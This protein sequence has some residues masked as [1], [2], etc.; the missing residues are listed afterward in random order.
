MKKRMNRSLSLLL[1]LV[2]CI[3]LLPPLPARAE[4]SV[5]LNLDGASSG[6]ASQV[7]QIPLAVGYADGDDHLSIVAEGASSTLY[8]NG[9]GDSVRRL[10]LYSA[11]QLSELSLAGNA[12]FAPG[13][14]FVEGCYGE[15]SGMYHALYY[16]VAEVTVSGSFQVK[17]G[18]D[19]V[20]DVTMSAVGGTPD[21]PL[22]TTIYVK[23]QTFTDGVLSSFVVRVSGFKLPTDQANSYGLDIG[24]NK[25]LYCQSLTVDGAGIDLTFN[26]PS[27]YIINGWPYLY[28]DDEAAFYFSGSCLSDGSFRALST[29]DGSVIDRCT[30]H[31]S[32]S[33]AAYPSY[34]GNNANFPS[35]NACLF[36]V[37]PEPE[38]PEFDGPYYVLEENAQ[39]DPG[40]GSFVVTRSD[41][42]VYVDPSKETPDLSDR[43]VSVYSAVGAPGSIQLDEIE[44]DYWSPAKSSF[45]ARFPR[46][47]F[48]GPGDY[49]IAFRFQKAEQDDIYRAI[50][51]HYIDPDA[52]LPSVTLAKTI[53]DDPWFDATISDLGDYDGG[54][55][56]IYANGT[57]LYDYW[58]GGQLTS[59]TPN[60]PIYIHVRLMDKQQKNLGRGTYSLSFVFSKDGVD[61]AY[62]SVELNYPFTTTHPPK[63]ASAYVTV[64]SGT[65]RAETHGDVCLLSGEDNAKFMVHAVPSEE[66]ADA[67]EKLYLANSAIQG[68][69]LPV[70][71]RFYAANNQLLANIGEEN[72]TNGSLI[73]RSDGREFAGLVDYGNIK[74]AVRAEVW[75][76]PYLEY[77]PGVDPIGISL[78][79]STPEE[80]KTVTYAPTVETTRQVD[81]SGK[82]YDAVKPGSTIDCIFKTDNPVGGTGQSATLTYI[83]MDNQEHTTTVAATNTGT[84]VSTAG[85]SA[86]TELIASIPVPG[87]AV[88][89]VSVTYTAPGSGGEGGVSTTYQIGKGG[90][91]GG[92]SLPV[93]KPV[94][95]TG[96]PAAYAGTV[97]SVQKV[98]GNSVSDVMSAVVTAANCA[99]IE[100]GEL[101]AGSYIWEI[102]GESGHIAGGT[103]IAPCADDTLALSDLPELTTLTVGAATAES[104]AYTGIQAEVGLTLTAPDNKTVN[105][106]GALS[107]Q[108]G[109]A[110]HPVAAA[111]AAFRQL[112]V[113]STITAATLSYDAAAYPDVSGYT[114]SLAELTE[115]QKTLATGEN[116]LSLFTFNAYTKHK[117]TG[118]VAHPEGTSFGPHVVVVLTQNVPRNG[119]A[120]NEVYTA[121]TTVDWQN[122]FS[123]EVYDGVAGT[124]E[125]RSLVFGNQAKSFDAGSVDRDIGECR[126]ASI[127]T[128]IRVDLNIQTP[129]PI[130]RRGYKSY[131]ASAST[132]VPG[133]SGTLLVKQVRTYTSSGNKKE[134]HYYEPGQLIDGSKAFE[135]MLIDGQLYVK[136][137]AAAGTP[138]AVEFM[139]PIYYGDD[140]MTLINPTAYVGGYE[141]PR[142]VTTAKLAGGEL[143]AKVASEDGDKT[144]FLCLVN[145]SRYTQIINGVNITPQT[146]T[147]VSGKGE[148]HL[149]YTAAQV[150]DYWNAERSNV[151][152]EG[153]LVFSL[154]CLDSDADA[155]KAMLESDLN[156]VLEKLD[157]GPGRQRERPFYRT[158]LP[159]NSYIYLNE[160]PENMV[161]WSTVGSEILPAYTFTYTASLGT[162][163]NNKDSVLISGTLK[164]RLANMPDADVLR[165]VQVTTPGQRSSGFDSGGNPTVE[166]INT[167]ISFTINGSQIGSGTSYIWYGPQKSRVTEYNV[168][169]VIP[170]DYYNRVNFSIVLTMGA[171]NRS[172]TTTQVIAISDGVDI[173]SLSGPTEVS[174]HDQCAAQNKIYDNKYLDSWELKLGLRATE[175]KNPD[176][177]KVTIWDN[178]VAIKTYT[179]PKGQ[180]TGD[181]VSGVKFNPGSYRAVW[182]RLTDNLAPG[183][184]VL[185]ASRVY[186]GNTICTEPISFM[187]REKNDGSAGATGTPY[188]SDITWTHSNWKNNGVDTETM[189]F[190]N[191]SDLAGFT[192]WLWPSQA[193]II[194]FKV[195]NV[196]STDLESVTMVVENAKGNTRGIACHSLGNDYWGLGE[197]DGD[198]VLIPDLAGFHFEFKYKQGSL[199]QQIQNATTYQQRRQLELQQ[200]CK[201]NGL[202]VPDD[203]AYAGTFSTNFKSTVKSDMMSFAN[204][205]SSSMVSG[206]M[207]GTFTEIK[208]GNERTGVRYTA[209][210]PNAKIKSLSSEAVIGEVKTQ[211][212]LWSLMAKEQENN[213][214]DNQTR[215]PANQ[216]WRVYWAVTDDVNGYTFTRV[217]EQDLKPASVVYNGAADDYGGT[218]TAKTDPKL[219]SYFENSIGEKVYT[220]SDGL[221]HYKTRQTVWLPPAVN[222]ALG[223]TNPTASVEPVQN[224]FADGGRLTVRSSLVLGATPPKEDVEEED[225]LA[226]QGFDYLCDGQALLD[227]GQDLY[228]GALKATYADWMLD[229]AK[230]G[231]DA[232]KDATFMHGWVGTTMNVLG[233]ADTIYKFCKGPSGADPAALA[234]FA[235]N[236][237]D[238]GIRNSVQKQ[239]EDYAHIRKAIF[240]N[241]TAVNVTNTGAGWVDGLALPYKVA[242]FV[243]S[244]INGAIS[245]ASKDYNRQA[246][247]SILHLVCDQIQYERMKASIPEAEQQLRAKMD[248]IYGKGR[249][250]ERQFM[251][252]K[253]NWVLRRGED[254]LYRYVWKATAPKFNVYHD[255]AGYVFEAT[256]DQRLQGVTATLYG[257][258]AKDGDYS[259]WQDTNADESAR[260]ANPL[261]TDAEGVYRWM[262]PSGWWKVQYRKDGYLDAESIEME[263]PPAHTAV[264]VGMLS[265]EAPKASV[266]VGTTDITVM[267]SKYMQM[268]SLLNL[269]GEDAVYTADT[270]DASVFKVRFYGADGAALEGT[271]SFPDKVENT[272]YKGVGYGRDVIASDWFVKTAVFTPDAE[273]T[274]AGAKYALANGMVSYAGVA[275]DKATAASLVMVSFDANGGT[276][277]L[278]D[279]VVAYNETA[280]L[281]DAVRD[282]YEF[283]GWYDN[284]TKVTGETKFTSSKTLTAHW[285]PVSSGTSGGSVAT[286]NL[287]IA[288]VTAENGSVSVGATASAGENAVGGVFMLAAYDV[289]GR[290]LKVVTQPITRQGEIQITMPADNNIVTVSAFIL[291]KTYAP[292]VGKKSINP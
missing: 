76:D 2:L 12:A 103:F 199:S 51:V 6:P 280:T 271:V 87:N 39:L 90:G 290:L 198:T 165:R 124:L 273:Q 217:A 255:P 167:N 242:L 253:L 155:V 60:E 139:N 248:Q 18:T 135:T 225:S 278:P 146:C 169:M 203:A 268:E 31:L 282:G 15:N 21:K 34:L 23:D 173:F 133:D 219:G 53:I 201:A 132:T 288:K 42:N 109:D 202:E 178:G 85:G 89:L 265:T 3:G 153:A 172:E 227:M 179:V 95:V 92:K 259:V 108:G 210:D 236:I 55:L 20:A 110:G 119:G 272:G 118:T 43:S 176:E 121:S 166:D 289:Q 143:R 113:G 116:S 231:E 250:T 216:G 102:T 150:G 187:L 230:R 66:W 267:F 286:G 188:V 62:V 111:P 189:H 100:I 13:S 117:I 64:Y 107:T 138:D 254:G 101:S 99:S 72:G 171:P 158:I 49:T 91:D 159:A 112:P 283:D 252:E 262:V 249:W 287:E 140:E 246:Y 136:V 221:Y 191:L 88:E 71:V 8:Y 180:N 279:Q 235:N 205:I 156:T 144:G 1:A 27:G 251:Q 46:S 123:F 126:L 122:K 234:A 84:T 29:D 127:E 196:V 93:Y 36:R 239:I 80:Y 185:Y 73:W 151:E 75:C 186:M 160:Y 98:V 137:N 204:T 284:E 164:K 86:G 224:I 260:Q 67:I 182:V 218:Y 212:E 190:D 79:V 270:Y 11:E 69:G 194:K 77:T 17:S 214:S 47:L 59:D 200:F 4:S 193:H 10:V 243:G 106:T 207:N 162:D 274:I 277:T 105:I 48:Y 114:L 229:G 128:T 291:S 266:S 57:E 52:S 184:H 161:P 244:K 9:S 28:I 195:N 96:I 70:Y 192:F 261:T 256:E 141:T 115:V 131:Q 264:N 238:E 226:R 81:E 257:S 24:D 38:T 258:T 170:L 82:A 65:A 37:P 281:Y 223:I 14:S 213:L 177:N 149:P 275:L 5:W 233:T 125:F 245:D 97:F 63:F 163:Q 175:S 240:A 19:T 68:Y 32:G 94:K 211:A 232:V 26:V 134:Y 54:S 148:L 120:A 145:K 222:T 209:T 206:A 45:P 181:T 237:K 152:T 276:Y 130:T 157:N 168:S 44:E 197:K 7:Y 263:V 78:S 285:T 16:Y 183:V 215:E 61:P 247:N 33:T 104:L 22:I 83:G 129:N 41:I 25:A 241:D 35:P 208:S 142:V 40:D 30:D 56:T 292:L 228:T 58:S 154:M 220:S 50:L 269:Y 147:F 174:I 74:T